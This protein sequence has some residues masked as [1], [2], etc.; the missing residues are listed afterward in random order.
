MADSWTSLYILSEL[1]LSNLRINF[2]H[3]NGINIKIK[4]NFIFHLTPLCHTYLL[5]TI[6]W[7]ITSEQY[8]G[9]PK[10]CSVEAKRGVLGNQMWAVR[11]RSITTWTRRERGEGGCRG[12][13]ESARVDH[14]AKGRYYVKCQGLSTREG[15]EGQSCV[16]FGPR[17]C[18]MT[19]NPNLWN[20]P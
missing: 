2:T 5:N 12:S 19:C 18:W 8:I 1:L 9:V 15:V 4:C 13:I 11:R 17:S 6:D 14:A 10:I 20:E 16:K 7:S 3:K